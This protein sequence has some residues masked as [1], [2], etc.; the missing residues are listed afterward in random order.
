MSVWPTGCIRPMAGLLL[1]AMLLGG[2][3]TADTARDVLRV[4]GADAADKLLG[5]AWWTVCK[6]SSIGAVERRYGKTVE[7]AQTYHRFCHGD[8]EANVIAP[9]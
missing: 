3:E 4:K 8:G 6:A 5:D 2:C 9:E 7:S 1:A